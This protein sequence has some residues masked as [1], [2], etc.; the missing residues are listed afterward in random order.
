[1]AEVIDFN[2]RQNVEA[3][4]DKYDNLHDWVILEAKVLPSQEDL[5]AGNWLQISH[6]L[7][8]TFLDPYSRFKN[9]HLRLFFVFIDRYSCESLWKSGSELQGITFERRADRIIFCSEDREH[10]YVEAK[11]VFFEAF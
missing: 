8:I 5:E 7:E 2:T 10:L 1:M 6:N 11:E 3:I 4:L 9:K